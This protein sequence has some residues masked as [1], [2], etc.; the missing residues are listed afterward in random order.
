MPVQ[1]N[2]LMMIGRDGGDSE[3][4]A[5]VHEDRIELVE[6]MKRVCL[7][8]EPEAIPRHVEATL[9]AALAVCQEWLMR[10]RGKQVPL[11]PPSL[12]QGQ[13]ASA[14][15]DIDYQPNPKNVLYT[16]SLVEPLSVLSRLAVRKVNNPKAPPPSASN[17]DPTPA[18]Q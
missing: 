11:P 2:L 4:S 13:A 9:N 15:E 18:S 5:K 16:P 7:G 10:P 8:V 3:E 6:Y 1:D 17:N 12:L 14:T